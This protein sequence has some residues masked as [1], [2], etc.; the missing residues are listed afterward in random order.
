MIRKTEDTESSPPSPQTRPVRQSFETKRG[1]VEYML[2]TNGDPSQCS[3][4]A[5]K[6]VSF[7]PSPPNIS[8]CDF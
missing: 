1:L 6:R 4:G 2:R 7:D 8:V 3:E 5:Q